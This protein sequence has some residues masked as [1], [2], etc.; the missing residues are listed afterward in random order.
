M[1]NSILE[2]TYNTREKKENYQNNPSNSLNSLTPNICKYGFNSVFFT[3]FL[4][5]TIKQ[6]RILHFLLNCQSLVD[7]K[8][9]FIDFDA[10]FPSL[11]TIAE[12]T[13]CSISTVKRFFQTLHALGFIT[14][15]QR[16]RDSNG[17]YSTN[18]YILTKKFKMNLYHLKRLKLF[19]NINNKTL[20]KK[21]LKKRSVQ[22]YKYFERFDTTSEIFNFLDKK[23]AAIKIKSKKPRKN[24]G[25]M[26]MSSRHYIK[27]R[28]SYKYK[29]TIDVRIFLQEKLKNLVI[30]DKDMEIFCN[31]S[32]AVL[33]EAVS[34]LEWWLSKGHRISEIRSH[35]AFFH[36][37]IL[38]AKTELTNLSSI[39]TIST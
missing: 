7:N 21:H 9:K 17:M 29:N 2:S 27:Y 20:Y 35:P 5:L 11:R 31:Y 32:Q 37:L 36:N 26:K 1:I 12:K 8:T 25:S 24:S 14:Y 4:Y 18:E 30:P 23:I 39:A 28:N 16:R 33:H 15:Y 13:G 10:I 6:K 34:K 19:N 22:I 38:R 3:L